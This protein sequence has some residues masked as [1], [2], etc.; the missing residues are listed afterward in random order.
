MQEDAFHETLFAD[1]PM[2]TLDGASI[3]DQQTEM[4]KNPALA[5]GEE[6]QLCNRDFLVSRIWA[7]DAPRGTVGKDFGASKNSRGLTGASKR[8]HSQDEEGYR[9]W[10]EARLPCA[11]R[12]PHASSQGRDRYPEVQEDSAP[13]QTKEIGKLD[14]Q[15]EPPDGTG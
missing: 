3:L 14:G 6:A 2:G 8:N 12:H 4:R 9:K 15:Q 1:R 10:D 7:I 11:K 5:E 13:C